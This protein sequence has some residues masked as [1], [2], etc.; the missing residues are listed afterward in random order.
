[1]PLMV[2]VA[3]GDWGGARPRDVEAVALSAAAAFTPAMDD[4]ESIGLTLEATAGDH[5]TPIALSA[6]ND[7]GEFVVRVSIRGN[8]WARLAYQFA[9]EFCHVLADLRTW[10]VDRLAWIE[11]CLCETASLFALRDMAKVWAHTPPYPNWRDYS[12]ALATYASERI[13]DAAHS[14]S[15]G[16]QVRDWLTERITLL[17]VDPNRR[18][19]N[20]IIAKELL[21]IFEADRTAWRVVRHLHSAS[22]SI[23]VSLAQFVAG[24][25]QSCPMEA[26]AAVD[27]ITRVLGIV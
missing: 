24:W 13:S 25:R 19:D 22:R 21:P 7:S 8:Q 1:M 11:E 26:R 5:G 27:S 23:A 4:A 17:E 10:T 6:L 12:S 15:P 16:L 9:H 2:R 14:L 3:D 20:T 18:E